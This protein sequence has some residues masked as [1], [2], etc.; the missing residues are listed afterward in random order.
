MFHPGKKKTF[1][2]SIALTSQF[3]LLVTSLDAHR[4]S[5]FSVRRSLVV[6]PDLGYVGA[7]MPTTESEAAEFAANVADPVRHLK[8]ETAKATPTGGQF[9]SCALFSSWRFFLKWWYNIFSREF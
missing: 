5:I 4:S 3:I 8:R 7:G 9:V 2:L 6:C 1:C